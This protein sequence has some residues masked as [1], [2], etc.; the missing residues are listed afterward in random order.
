MACK[1][2]TYAIFSNTR[3]ENLNWSLKAAHANYTIF[4][5]AQVHFTRLEIKSALEEEENT[6]HDYYFRTPPP[7]VLFYTITLNN[8]P[9]MTFSKE[10]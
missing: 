10:H 3:K 2:V 7:F 9:A 1:N 6:S 5:K 4:F 8:K